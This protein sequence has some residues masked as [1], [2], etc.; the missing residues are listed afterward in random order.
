MNR[1]Q[2]RITIQADGGIQI[3]DPGFDALPLLRSVNPGFRIQRSPLPGF[4]QPRFLAT[5]KTGAGHSHA[6]LRKMSEAE[7]WAIHRSVSQTRMT[8]KKLGAGSDMAS[9]LDLKI[10][11]AKRILTHC[12]L[13]GHRC[14]INRLSGE[15]GLCGL[16]AESFMVESYIHI[17]EESPI[18][19]SLM[20]TLSGCGLDCIFCQQPNYRFP[21]TGSGISLNAFTWDTLNLR[22]A[23]SLSFIGGNPDESL[24]AILS[25]LRTAPPDW[26]L[27]VVWNCHSYA[28]RETTELLSSIV[29]AYVPDFKYGCDDCAIQLSGAPDYPEIATA[30]ISAMVAQNVPVFVRLLILP[31]HTDCCH[32]PVMNALSGMDQRLLRVSLRGQYDPKNL[33]SDVHTPLCPLNMA[34]RPTFDEISQVSAHAHRLELP[35]IVA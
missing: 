3:V 30:A 17:A 14:G 22:G 24:F 27:P 26:K 28:S 23:R 8:D 7:L 9:L 32:I 5:R 1:K 29:D 18:N 6:E 4:D 16:G 31:G 10:E 25:F 21:Q 15:H 11:L 2:M 35:L 33:R 12:C 34:R 13:C 20:L 19:P